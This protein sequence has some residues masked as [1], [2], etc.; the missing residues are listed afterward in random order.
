[1]I[2]TEDEWYKAAYW[3]GSGYSTY[4]NGTDTPPVVQVDANYSP[5]DGPWNIATGSQE[6]NGTFNM[7]G[8]V[9]EWSESV[10]AS[11][12]PYIFGGWYSQN[13]HYFSRRGI[14]GSTSAI[15]ES[16]S[17]GLRIIELKRDSD[18]DGLPD[19]WELQ[20]FGSVDKADP[21]AFCSNGVDKVKN[22]YIAGINP[23]DPQC[24]FSIQEIHSLGEDQILQW[25]TIS[26][27]V[28]S[29]Y[30]TTNLL[31]GFQC[32]DSNIPWTRA[33]FTNSTAV[34]CG[35]YKIGVQ[36]AD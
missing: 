1:M 21:D 29:V 32:L 30:W 26:G 6:Q 33:D 17:R 3:T 8:N 31:S 15:G 19:S 18:G 27:R 14:L 9:A 20:Y 23:N 24:R 7:M 11:Q 2:P 10:T 34:P 28:Y 25:N 4:A 36:L 35:Y 12:N 22:A 5:T 16:S 13:D